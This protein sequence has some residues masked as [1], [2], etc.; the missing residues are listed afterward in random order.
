MNPKARLNIQTEGITFR[1]IC[2]EVGLQKNLHTLQ[3][4]KHMSGLKETIPNVSLSATI[5][6]LKDISEQVRAIQQ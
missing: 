4:Q 5:L 6:A 2:K 3:R 1:D